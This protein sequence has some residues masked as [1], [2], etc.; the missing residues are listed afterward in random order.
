[1]NIWGKIWRGVK[2]IGGALVAG[3][4]TAAEGAVML[5]ELGPVGVMV[6]AIGGALVG[7]GLNMGK[8]LDF[9]NNPNGDEDNV[10]VKQVLERPAAQV[11]S[12]ISQAVAN[13]SE[14]SSKII[15]NTLSGIKQGGTWRSSFAAAGGHQFGRAITDGQI[16]GLTNRASG[17]LGVHPIA[18][19]AQGNGAFRSL[20]SRHG[21]TNAGYHG[22]N[23]HVLGA[24]YPIAAA[25]MAPIYGGGSG[26]GFGRGGAGTLQPA[27]SGSSV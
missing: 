3:L 12:A 13:P 5:S 9:V 7:V 14:P 22:M 10:D 1:M 8:V 2:A 16:Q 27:S 19:M 24:A 21:Q 11:N 6:G 18:L 15:M 20:L 25:A 23:D 4:T 26:T 17:Q